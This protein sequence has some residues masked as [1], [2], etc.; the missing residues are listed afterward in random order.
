M[1]TAPDLPSCL[2]YEKSVPGYAIFRW[3]LDVDMAEEGI[4]LF[5]DVT[6]RKFHREVL[7]LPSLRH[8][9]FRR[10]RADKNAA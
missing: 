3:R 5:Q 8:L 4:C 1:L 6:G 9:R 7:V 2:F 10:G